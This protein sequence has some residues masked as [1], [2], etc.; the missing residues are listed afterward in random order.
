[1]SISSVNYRETLLPKPDI[2]RI[3]G[4]PTY[5]ALHQ[6]QLKI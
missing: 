1:M 3:L 4:I 5:N 2:T 6:M